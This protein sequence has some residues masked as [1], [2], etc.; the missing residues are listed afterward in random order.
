MK[1]KIFLQFLL[2]TLLST[3]L[4]FSCGVIAVNVNAKNILRDRLSYETEIVASLMR[5]ASDFSAFD[6]YQ[7]SGA[8]RL[9]VLSTDGNVIYE[10]DTAAELE[11]HANREE[12]INA[13]NDTPKAVERYSD[14]FRAKMTYY[15]MK[16]T[17][18]SG[19]EVIVRLA[20]KSSEISSYISV[21]VPLMAAA[22]I[23]VFALSMLLSGILCKQISAKISGVGESLKS[24][25]E[26]RYRPLVVNSHEPEFYEVYNEINDLNANIYSHIT[27][28]EQEHAKLNAVLESVS[29]GIVALNEK[30]QAVF[31]NRSAA[32]LLGGRITAED[33]GLIYL[34][35][36]AE[37]YEKITGHLNENYFF[38]W[39]SGEK[40]LSVAIT[41]I[42]DETIKNRIS[43]IV[44]VTDIT[45]AKDALRQRSDFFANA[46]HELKTPITVIQGLS[47]LLLSKD[48]G[49]ETAA[50]QLETLHKECLRLSSLVS[51]M[52]KLSNL[53]NGNA[54]S[55]ET[56]V[57]VN[58]SDT[59]R[60][61]LS[62]LAGAIKEKQITATVQGDSML[63]ADPKKIYELVQNLC[64][65]AVNYNKPGGK[66]TVEIAETEQN[67][68]LCVSD[69][70]IGVKK[71]NIPRLC[72]RFYRVDKSRSKRTGGTGLGLAIV[73]HVCAL[74]DATLTI[75]SEYGEGTRVCAVFP[76]FS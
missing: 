10:S 20:V 32:R 61:A 5:D 29:Q 9:T 71:E 6:R 43:S 74:Y 62:E 3:L 47:E 40:T 70:G 46:S 59:A 17:L 36:N 19:E 11:N 31:A 44:V 67:V 54:K 52:L 18:Q 51:D 14:T 33:N 65:N 64:S 72:E 48:V 50:K 22:L 34:I 26:G 7:N 37:L 38:E 53:E 45:A 23:G 1:R 66:I 39:Q 28:E 49:D 25:N 42:T 8:F 15:A 55:E 21:S 4:M 56:R 24:L 63:L 13:L 68:T 12:I 69:T 27:K 76:K 75:E 2:I 30:K 73:K 41:K 57:A 16:T 35:E 60:E 58:L